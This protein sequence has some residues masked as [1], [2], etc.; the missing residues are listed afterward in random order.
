MQVIVHSNNENTAKITV[1]HQGEVIAE[2]EV[3]EAFGRVDAKASVCAVKHE[4]T[5]TAPQGDTWE[6]LIK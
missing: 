6:G 1:L 5:L 4:W 2:L 3:I